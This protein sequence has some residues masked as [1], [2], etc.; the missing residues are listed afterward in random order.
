MEG[1][2]EKSMEQVILEDGR[3]PPEAFSFLHEGLTQAVKEIYG[4]ET[5]VEGQR[6]VTGRQL[7][8]ALRDLAVQRWGMLAKVVLNKW[9]IHETIDF[10]NMVY[11]LVESKHMR[12]TEEDSLEDFRGI[13]DFD[14]AFGGYRA[15]E[16]KE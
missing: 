4:E 11:L 10:G 12:K 2:P 13:F 3:Y 8:E 9:N 5:P 15:F 16:L 14:K 7:C 1:K 6:H